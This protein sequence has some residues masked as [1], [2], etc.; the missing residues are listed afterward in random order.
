[1][2][3]GMEYR[4][5]SRDYLLRAQERL[6][7]GTRE[8]LFYA[9][10][11]LRCGIEARMRQYLEVCDHISKKKKEGWKIA[12]LGRGTEEAFRLG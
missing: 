2:K 1:M 6:R 8:A 9:A 11:E 7:D 5:S 4:T 3:K 10:F 12:D